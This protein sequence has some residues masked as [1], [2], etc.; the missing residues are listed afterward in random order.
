MEQ[1]LECFVD[2]PFFVRVCLEDRTLDVIVPLYLCDCGAS[3]AASVGQ[4]F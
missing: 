4:G 3:A 2:L 1:R